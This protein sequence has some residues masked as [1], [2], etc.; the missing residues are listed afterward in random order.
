[1]VLRYETAA[2]N[3]KKGDII[4]NN[5][6]YTEIYDMSE[7]ERGCH[8]ILYFYDDNRTRM[9]IMNAK[10]RVVKFVLDDIEIKN[11]ENVGKRILEIAK[12]G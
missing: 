2:I 4:I 10:Q 12:N 9:L 5:G 11:V 8:I 1:M 3:L 7:C 6:Y